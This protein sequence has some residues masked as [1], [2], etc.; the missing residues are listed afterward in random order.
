[1]EFDKMII[2]FKYLNLNVPVLEKNSKEIGYAL[3]LS[4]KLLSHFAVYF[5]AN[6]LKLI[7]NVIKMGFGYQILYF[8]L[9]FCNIAS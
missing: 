8:L 7:R 5:H 6:S 4:Y 9:T 1:M 3:N 2:F